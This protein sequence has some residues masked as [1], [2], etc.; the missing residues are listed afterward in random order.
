[1]MTS[2]WGPKPGLAIDPNAPPD[3][4]L[5][6]LILGQLIVRDLDDRIIEALEARAS[7]HRWS[8]EDELREILERAAAE[9]V[10][11]VDEARERAERIGR[12]LEGRPHS[13]SA[14]LIRE[15]RRR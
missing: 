7:R 10:V 11:D 14:A 6:V 12:S 3:P 2:G 4:I 1:M 13:D 15:D 5:G 9:R 8:L